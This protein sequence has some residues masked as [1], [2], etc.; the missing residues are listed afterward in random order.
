MKNNPLV[1]EQTL[2]APVEKVWDAITNKEKM[3][4][5]YFELSDF[6]PVVGFQ[7]SFPGQGHKGENY[8]HLCKVTAVEPNKKIQYSW[9]YENYEGDSLVTFELFEEGKKTRLRLTHEGLETFPQ[10]NP[11]FA[12]ESFTGGWTELITKLLVKF[13]EQ[14]EV[15]RQ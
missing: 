4:Q 8:I 7:F 3:K 13:L 9:R 15:V 10:N 1:I 5:W 12:R 14:G 2:D 6:K 11:D